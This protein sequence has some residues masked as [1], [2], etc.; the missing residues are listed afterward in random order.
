[1]AIVL[2]SSAEKLKGLRPTK[3]IMYQYTNIKSK[4]AGYPTNTG[5]PGSDSSH[6]T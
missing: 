6:A 1:M 3:R 2:M 4:A 5:N